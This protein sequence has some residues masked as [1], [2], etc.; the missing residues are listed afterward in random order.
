[1]LE[2]QIVAADVLLA[3]S[4]RAA[5]EA[6]LRTLDLQHRAQAPA[7][8]ATLLPFQRDLAA[9]LA[10]R[11][12]AR[13]LRMIEMPLPM[14]W[15]AAAN[16]GD[17][18]V[19]IPLLPLRGP[20]RWTTAVALLA[21]LLLVFGAAAWYARSL[22]RP[23]HTLAAA[24]PSLAAGEPAPVM[25]R[26]AVI[27]IAELA[28]ALD[29]AAAD[30]RAAAQ[31]RQLMLA[32]LSHDMRTP[33]ARLVLALE[34]LGGG[35]AAIR[36]GM[37]VDIAELDAI[38]GQFIA[39]VRDGR[40][41]PGQTIDLGALLD[42]ALAAQRRGGH[43]WQ[44]GGESSLSVYA[45]PLALRRALD[46]LL[47]NAARHGAPAFEV[48]LYTLPNGASLCVRDHGAGVAA[49]ALPD[50]GRPFYRAD[51][52]RVGPGT[53]LGLATV[54]RIAAWHGGTLELR[55]CADGG[56]EAEMRLVA[57]RA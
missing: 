5:A 25:P 17:G 55:N 3:Q 57:A 56:F 52:A 42:D 14:L 53:G 54:A 30:T 48:K 31:E 40:D 1:V 43:E 20:L 47:E 2:S 15:V 46:N 26:H 27:E 21:G 38:I 6:R 12:P 29:R 10:Q 32:G 11:L 49:A 50:L 34:L 13:E 39:F 24:A 28:A 8:A 51:T 19:G 9:E 7:A 44:R 23:L 16:G 4:D 33:L 37:A 36:A 41:E 18:W 45:K 22:V 35:D